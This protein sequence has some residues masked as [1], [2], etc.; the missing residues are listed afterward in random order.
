M[1]RRRS[2]LLLAVLVLAILVGA[3][4][5]WTRPKQ[6][7]MAT[8]APADSLLYL[9]ANHPN[10]VLEAIS[11]TQAWRDLENALGSQRD[12]ATARWLQQFISW[13]GIGPARSVILSRA[14]V[15][16]V[17]TDLRTAEE[18]DDLNIKP[19]GVLLIETHTAERRVKPVFEAELKTLAEK[20][21]GRP[22]ARHVS[23]DGIE[24]SEWLAPEGSRQIVG[25]VFGS[26]VVIG[27]SERV[28][29]ECLTVAQGRRPSLRD[30]PDLAA[31]RARLE[32]GPRLTFG[33]VPRA[34]SAKLLAFGMPIL[35]GRAPGDSDFQRIV[36]TGAAKIF[37]SLG[38]T[39]RSYL[40]GI[41]DEYVIDLQ[42]SA[43][44]RLKPSFTQ[45]NVS[46]QIQQLIPNDVYSVTSYRFN[47]P[48]AAWQNLSGMVS[49]QVDALS[50]IVFAKLL[51][52]ALLTYGIAE[53]ETFLGTVNEEIFTLRT[54]ENGERS[55]LIAGVRDRPALRKF[56]SSTMSSVDSHVL[57][58]W[59]DEVFLDSKEDVG[60]CLGD[61]I[62]VMG[63]AAELRRYSD[64]RAAGDTSMALD[65]LHRMTFFGATATAPNI[66]SYTNDSERI[67]SFYSTVMMSK[68]ATAT[69]QRLDETIAKLPYSV[70]ET[71]LEDHGIIRTTRS[72][73]GQF[74]TLL[75]LLLPQQTVSGKNESQPK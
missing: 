67:R 35:M 62:V 60:A 20:T 64:A 21:Y 61:Q 68:G 70:T 40:S 16:V 15:A 6:V 43:L 13:T 45:P 58:R 2:I 57:S 14:Q 52:S 7:D 71:S 51:N 18:G 50:A 31:M 19:E 29:Q 39:S 48:A 28:V 5:W 53:P 66:V 72:P 30:D 27:T 65:N 49:S 10:D 23:L 24:F 9:E 17:V 55:I 12:A 46:S 36:A 44:A 4:L 56:L 33:Y 73:L 74:S 32:Q 11:A 47:N 34:N 1:R 22:T 26:L 41:E 37:G 42:P 69:P 59:C 38:W 63:S 75:P 54:D 25:T 3:S 8:Y